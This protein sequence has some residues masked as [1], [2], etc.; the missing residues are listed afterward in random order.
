M[1]AKWTIRE[2]VSVIGTLTSSFSGNRFSTL[3][4]RAMLKF[5]D[6]FLKYNKG[7]FNAIIKLSEDTLHEISLCKKNILKKFKIQFKNSKI[8]V[9]I[10]TDASLKYWSASMGNVP[11][12]GTWLPDKKLMYINV[13]E[14][15]AILLALNSFVKT[16]HKHINVMSG[17]IIPIHCINKM[18]I[19]E[20]TECHQQVLKI[21]EWTIIHENHL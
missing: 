19:S 18:G 11:T 10:Y 15:K 6:K 4:F 8:S 3:Y 21:W 1:K 12:G 13:L 16:S 7:N 17:N 20:S 14:L 5:K 9:T 2:F